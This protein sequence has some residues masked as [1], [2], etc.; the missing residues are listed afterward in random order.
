MASSNAAARIRDIEVERRDV[1]ARLA[2]VEDD[3]SQGATHIRGWLDL[4]SNPYELCRNA[5]DEMRRQLNQALFTHLW[6]INLDQVDA[7]FT[8]LARE[9]IEAQMRWQP[10]RHEEAVSVTNARPLTESPRFV[11]DRVDLMSSSVHDG[12]GWSKHSLVDLRGFEPLTSSMRTRR[13]TNCAT[14]PD[15]STTL[16]RAPGSTRPGRPPGRAVPT[17]YCPDARRSRS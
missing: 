17:G 1:E 13:A 4:L 9:L 15:N 11:K 5:S 7:D 8:D 12:N 2:S 14:G 6:V 16:S 3:L 10:L